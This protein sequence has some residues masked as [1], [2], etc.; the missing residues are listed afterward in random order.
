M[1]F[2]TYGLNRKMATRKTI[3]TELLDFDIEDSSS[4]L[5][6]FFNYLVLS[7]SHTAIQEY[8]SRLEAPTRTCAVSFIL[9]G[10]P[11]A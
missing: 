7:T 10:R 5:I 9:Q 2:K 8:P 3:F 6:P 1:T 11:S 4:L